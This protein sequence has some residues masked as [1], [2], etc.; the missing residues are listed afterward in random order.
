M[1][2]HSRW[3]A[4]KELSVASGR[5]SVPAG[6]YGNQCMQKGGAEQ[7]QERKQDKT[8]KNRAGADAKGRVCDVRHSTTDTAAAG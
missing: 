6:E 4:R 8:S 3:A 5:C 2:R 1:T 7:G